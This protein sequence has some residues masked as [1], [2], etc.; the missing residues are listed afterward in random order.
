MKQKAFLVIT[1]ALVLGC[2]PLPSAAGFQFQHHF[3]DRQ[4]PGNSWA[5]T[6]LAD[7]D[8]DGRLD[9]ITGQTRGP[10][11]W[12]RQEAPDRW[13]RHTLGTNSPS[14]VGGAALDVDGDGWVD[15]IAGGVW[16]R[17]TGRPRT[18]PFERIVFDQDL[19][20]VHDL[21]VAD[22]DR[23]GRSD[24]LTMSDKNN[25]RWYRIPRD[26]RQA[27]ERHDIGPGVHAGI[28]VG[29]LDGD[30]DLDV[31]RSNLWFENADGRGTR[32]ITHENI[33]FGNPKQPYP[34]GTH[35]VALDVDRDG[36]TDLLMTENEIKAGR[37]GW[38]ENLDG[39][40]GGWKLH[41]LPKGD[42]AARGAYHSLVVDD[43]D[44]DGDPDIF[45]CEMEGIPG[46]KPPRWFIWE[47]SD[48]KGGQFTEHVILD[49]NL[50]GHLVVAGDVDGDGDLDL[51]GKLWRPRRDN[52]NEGRNHVDLL[53]NRLVA[54][55]L[56]RLRASDNQR[57]LVTGSGQPFFWLGDTSWHMFGKSAREKTTNQPAVS[58][59]FS[60]R[61]AKGFT[62]IQSVIVRWP[63]GGSSANAYGFEPFEDGD[64]ARPRL[65]PGPN[66]DY[67]DHVDWCIAEARRHR[68]Y[69]AGLPLWLSAIEDDNPM[70]RDP[71]VSY[72]YGHFLG[73]RYGKEPHLIWVLGGD[74]YQ[75]GRNV[76]V[77]ARLA[78]IRAQAEGIADG[79]NGVDRFDGQADWRTTLMTFH[80]PGGNHSSS[81]W[82]HAEPWLDFNMI[83]TTTRFSFENWRTVAK[84]YARQPPKPTFDAE[85]AYEG[86]LTLRQTEPQDRRIRPWDARRAAYWNVFAGGLGHTY[87]HRSFIGWIRKNETYRY[88]AHIPWY[89][90]LDAP[91]AFQM[92]HL[93]R[94]ME[95]RP[96]LTRI[97]DQSVIAG[98]LLTADEH[99]QATR[100]A[101]GAYAMVYSPSGRPFQV[102]MDKMAGL[103]VKAW[104]FNPS[105][106]GTTALGEFAN[107]GEREFT[108]PTN[109]ED[110]DWVLVLDDADKGYAPPA[111]ARIP[112]L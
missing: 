87:G 81:E 8:K 11:F 29:D 58:L 51:V 22:V 78:M 45:S 107:T 31:A 24:I 106:G 62:V 108:P 32:W 59:Y 99:L 34:L 93:R 2:F 97:P 55:S 4:L 66:D 96:F 28:G 37:I 64:W 21:V 7:V 6:A 10:I 35:C 77:P 94:L 19:A 40:G 46:D 63:E 91:V 12:Y 103:K 74:A 53:E 82:L 13:V 110:N 42:T 5:Q 26:P 14:D 72:R 33:P 88:G 20:A 86:S 38:L 23:D 83:Q 104:W 80:P 75:K 89:E 50:G 16:Y 70:V 84:D 15:F 3:M 54:P 71:R 27:W 41:E 67:W 49:A 109:G 102:R 79:A 56:P 100:D 101:A 43:F 57:F 61:A 69:V 90:S 36:D 47:N 39:R 92:G 25:L 98:D 112:D 30:G 105:T 17:N 52:A 68:L 95:S 9:Y 44:N 1:V 65:R 18:E 111:S 73:A 85:V 76:D 60:N 48:G